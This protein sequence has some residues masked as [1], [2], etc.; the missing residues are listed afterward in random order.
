MAVNLLQELGGGVPDPG[1]T[2]VDLRRP[3]TPVRL[4]ATLPARLVGLP[5]TRQEVV[6]TLR[7]I[8]CEVE[9]A[10]EGTDLAVLPPSWRPD[11]QDGADFAEEVARLRGYDQI[12]SV[13]PQAPGG[14]GLTHDQRVRR[15]VADTLAHHGL[16]RGPH[17]PLRGREGA[18]PARA[19][20][21][22]PAAHTRCGWPT[23]CPRRRR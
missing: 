16:R 11:L 6:D 15:V 12:P 20:G 13:L 23:R 22:R 9:D 18:R 7:E 8:G 19:R 14:R 17:L 1:V 10:G 21:R 5:W 3:R 4:D 2:D